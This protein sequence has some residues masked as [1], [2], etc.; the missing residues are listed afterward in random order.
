MAREY[1]VIGCRRPHRQEQTGVCYKTVASYTRWLQ[2]G[3]CLFYQMVA[4][5]LLPFMPDGCNGTVVCY[6]RWLQC[7]GVVVCYTKWMQWHCRL[8]YHMVTMGLSS[9]I[10]G[11]CNGA[12]VYYTRLLQWYCR[13]YPKWIKWYCRLLYQ[14]DA[15]ILSEATYSV[16][17]RNNSRSTEP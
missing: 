16:I 10:P 15:V 14:M 6:T 9:I 8:L 11:C 7:N 2:W 4:M 12:V 17:I 13:L 3:C 1:V 5:G